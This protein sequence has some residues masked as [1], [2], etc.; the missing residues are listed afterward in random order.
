MSYIVGSFNLRDFNFSNKSTD[1]ANE[2][3]KRDFNKIAEIILKEKF[4][5]IALQEVNAEVPLKRL[6]SILNMH[7]NITREYSWDFGENMPFQNGSHDPE[8][9]GFIWN[10]KRLRLLKT[11]GRNPGYYQNAGAVA[12][13]RP[14][15]LAR[16]T[17]RG[18]LGGCNFELRLVNTHIKYGNSIADRVVEFNILV[19]QIL[20]R[21]CDFQQVSDEGEIMPSY[22]FLLGDYNL[23]LNRSERTIYKIEEV[24]STSY[25]GKLRNYLTTQKEMTSLKIPNNQTSIEDCYANNYDHFSYEVGGSNGLDS[26][27]ILVPQRVEA[28]S[29][30]FFEGSGPENKLKQYREKVSDHV[31]IKMIVDFK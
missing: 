23:E 25:T 14:P 19:Q 21:I 27:L 7:K 22:T 11:R 13:I 1:G 18:L 30:Y 3:I 8:R 9:Y 26:K 28:L 15:Y 12:L 5:V 20:P 24:T 10:V 29:K 6:V 31:P 4:D 17:A 2:K 16:F